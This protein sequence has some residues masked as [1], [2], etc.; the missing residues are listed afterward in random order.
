MSA[1]DTQ[2]GGDH[3]KELG[4]YQ[5]WEVLKHWLT[6]EEFRGFMKGTA[7]AY[8]A[9]ERSKGGMQ[10]ISKAAHTLDGLVELMGINAPPTAPAKPTPEP[11]DKYGWDAKKKCWVGT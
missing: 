10:D 8:L 3:Y 9:R 2:V 4:A 5:P 1:L 7:I 11:D 6:P